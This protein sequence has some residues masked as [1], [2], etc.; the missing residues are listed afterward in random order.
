MVHET[1]VTYFIKLLVVIIKWLKTFK[2]MIKLHEFSKI[3]II[4]LFVHNNRYLPLK[5][6]LADLRP[7]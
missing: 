1:F 7:T 4:M 2:S 6:L 3:C 5:G